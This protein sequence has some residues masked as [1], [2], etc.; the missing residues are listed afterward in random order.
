MKAMLSKSPLLVADLS[1]ALLDLMTVNGQSVDGF[2][3]GYR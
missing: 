3:H 1:E 2:K